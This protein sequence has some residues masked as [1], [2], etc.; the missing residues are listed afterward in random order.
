M[1]SNPPRDDRSV[2]AAPVRRADFLRM[3]LAG[4][5]V[6]I[7][8]TGGDPSSLVIGIPAVLAAA[9]VATTSGFGETMPRALPLLAFLPFFLGALLGSAWGLARRVLARDPQFRPGVIPWRL[10]LASEGARAAFMNVVS[11]TPGTLSA[12]LDGDVLSVHVLDTEED[13]APS[14]ADLERR[15]ARL[16]GEAPR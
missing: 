9:W 4:L 2:R 16:Y 5:V 11:L 6:W 15:V 14:L 12:S 3:A 1:P 7:A 13:V 10:G 8:L